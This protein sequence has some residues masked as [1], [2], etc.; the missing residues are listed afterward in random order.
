MLLLRPFFSRPK[1]RLFIHDQ[2]FRNQNWDFLF[3]TK[4][5]ETQTELFFRPNSPKPKLPKNWQNSRNREVPKP[6]WHAL[7]PLPLKWRCHLIIAPSFFAWENVITTLCLGLPLWFCIFGRCWS[8]HNLLHCQVSGF[9]C[10]SKIPSSSCD[11]FGRLSTPNR[12]H[13][14]NSELVNTT[15]FGSPFWQSVWGRVLPG[16]AERE[17]FRRN[18]LCSIQG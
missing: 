14:R 5:F 6:K 18:A 10:K 8:H 3:Q 4:F 1:L 12:L 16:S 17:A 13:P 7:P 2:I 11:V 15:F 9:L